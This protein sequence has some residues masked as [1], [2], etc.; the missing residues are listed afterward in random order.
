M[1]SV[2]NTVDNSQAEARPSREQCLREAAG[3]YA[4]WRSESNARAAA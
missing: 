4:S 3:V 2:S 1:S